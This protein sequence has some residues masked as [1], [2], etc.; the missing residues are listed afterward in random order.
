MS[1]TL[2]LSV[3]CLCPLHTFN[4]K[5]QIYSPKLDLYKRLSFPMTRITINAITHSGIFSI[6]RY[7]R[8]A[9][10]SEPIYRVAQKSKHYRES[11]LN[12]IKNRQPG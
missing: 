6:T 5:V 9:Y 11:S 10:V 4:W 7:S 8:P 1:G 12:R 3:Y 2:S